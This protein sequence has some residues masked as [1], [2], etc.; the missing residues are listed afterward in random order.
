MQGLNS[1]QNVTLKNCN[2][3]CETTAVYWP[4][5][6]GTLTIEDTSI[7][8]KSGVTIKGG[9][10][11]VKGDTHIKAAGEKKIPEDYYDGS[12]SGNLISTGAAIY[13]ESG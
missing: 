8:A 5:K 1:N 3:T 4:P 2:I 10:V 13:V 7:E 9:S 12:P 6:S 11:V